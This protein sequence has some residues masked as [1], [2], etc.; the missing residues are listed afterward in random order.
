MDRI[1]FVTVATTPRDDVVPE[2][3]KRLPSNVKVIE[4]GLLDG[5][6]GSEVSSLRP[7][8]DEPGIVARIANRGEVLLSH[9]KILP[10]IQSLVDE[11]EDQESPD[12]TVMLCGADWSSLKSKSFLVNPG[13][14]FPNIVTGMIGRGR[15]GVIKPNIGQ[16]STERARY[17][18]LGVNAVVASASPYGS[19]RLL[20]ATRAADQLRDGKCDLVWMTCIGMD[21]AMR[22]TVSRLV[23]VPVI[24]ARSILG[25]ILAELSGA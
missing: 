23:G 7:E 2:L 18:A 11:L 21:N 25:A 16:I 8:S 20:E 15:L 17:A 10:R 13:A 9:R 6:S 1:G 24:L 5:L 22:D 14:L 12:M 4:R 19:D 3:S